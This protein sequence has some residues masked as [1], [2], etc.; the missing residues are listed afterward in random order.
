[1]SGRHRRSLRLTAESK[2]RPDCVTRLGCWSLEATSIAPHAFVEPAG[3]RRTGLIAQPQPGQLDHR[4][5]QPGVAGLRDAL[6]VPD[7]SALPGCQCKP[8]IGCDL[9]AIVEVPEQ[10][11]RVQDGRAL[12]AN[13][14]EVEQGGRR[15]FGDFGR[16]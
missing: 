13:A 4:R 11:F 9:S 15:G 10:P 8:G 7:R 16:K 6:L 2:S 1:M 14:L 5:S 12:R 3:E